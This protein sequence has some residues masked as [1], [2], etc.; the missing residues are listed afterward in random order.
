MLKIKSSEYIDLLPKNNI[1]SFKVI[2]MNEE[3]MLKNDQFCYHLL[4][5]NFPFDALCWAL[6]ELELIFEKGTKK[7][8]ERDVIKRAQK[9]F[10]SELDYDTLCWSI[11]RLKTYLEWIKSYP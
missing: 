7:Y 1:K 3:L 8:S 2:E 10:D 6:A 11:S 9:I 5:S 4:N